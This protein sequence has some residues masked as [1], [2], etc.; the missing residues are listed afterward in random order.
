MGNFNDFVERM[1]REKEGFAE[2]WESNRPRREFINHIAKIRVE[3]GLTQ[4]DLA[5]KIG[6]HQSAIARFESGESNPALKTILKIVEALDQKLTTQPV[7]LEMESFAGKKA[8]MFSDKGKFSWSPKSQ[9]FS[10][11]EYFNDKECEAVG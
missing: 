1:K 6:L 8:E 7:K 3:K 9:E 11:K 4:S 2:V 10:V 5:Q